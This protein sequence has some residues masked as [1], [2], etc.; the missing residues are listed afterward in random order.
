[1]GHPRT[2]VHLALCKEPHATSRL[3]AALARVL[4]SHALPADAAFELKV[5]ATEAVTN[6]IKGAPDGHTVKV[7]I[8]GS[9]EG[10]DVEVAD[11]GRF[12][13]KSEWASGLDAEGGRGIPLM[14]ALVDEVEFASAEHGTRVRMRKRAPR[15]REDG[16]PAPSS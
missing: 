2:T 16:L 12:V 5:A 4:R 6:A 13:P 11:R 9:D 10:I 7:A 1:M 14:R 8:T 3:R 15:G